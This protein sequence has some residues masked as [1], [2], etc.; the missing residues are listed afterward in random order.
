LNLLY[1]GVLSN[2]KSPSGRLISWQ[3]PVLTSGD[4]PATGNKP[5]DARVA[6]DTV[7]V[8]I[9]DGSMWDTT[10]A[11]TRRSISSSRLLASP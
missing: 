8:W 10:S 6:L 7:Q 3:D 4:L 11:S 2:R 1:D 5:G 9:W